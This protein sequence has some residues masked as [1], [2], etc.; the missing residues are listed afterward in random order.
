MIGILNPYAILVAA[1]AHITLGMVWYSPKVMGR[2]WARHVGLSKRD[3]HARMPKRT[4]FITIFAALLMATVLSFVATIF[5]RNL[6]GGFLTGFLSWAGFVATTSINPV[7]WEK[8]DPHLFFVNN[9]YY[10][11]SMAIMGIIVGVWI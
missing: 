2:D 1:A 5:Q 7:V 3:L 6:V 11:F 9:T 10:L 4:F 8:R